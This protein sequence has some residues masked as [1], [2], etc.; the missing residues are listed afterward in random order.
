MAM[1]SR[2]VRAALTPTRL[3]RPVCISEE[4]E[5]RFWRK[6]NIDRRILG[7]IEQQVFNADD[8]R[9]ERT[10]G[11][12][13][14]L[15][16]LADSWHHVLDEY[17]GD[18]YGPLIDTRSPDAEGR[19][20]GL[21]QQARRLDEQCIRALQ[22]GW[23][24]SNAPA[25]AKPQYRLWTEGWPATFRS[26]IYCEPHL[27]RPDRNGGV[28]HVK[29]V[30][31]DDDTVLITSVHLTETALDWT[32]EIGPLVP[33]GARTATISALLHDPHREIAPPSTAGAM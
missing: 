30:A 19:L 29:V 33:E 28:L 3:G 11:V 32:I 4:V 22:A 25:R 18:V 26:G 7:R 24:T 23:L 1:V 17:P 5:H 16:D 31:I 9:K 13:D 27:L 21:V 2:P 8:E 10:R 12:Q 20:G 15:V 14:S 6:W